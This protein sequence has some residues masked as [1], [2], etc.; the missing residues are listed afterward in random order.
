[1]LLTGTPS[2]TQSAGPLDTHYLDLLGHLRAHSAIVAPLRARRQVIGALTVAGGDGRQPFTEEDLSLVDELCRGLA[3]GVDNARLYQETRNIA[4]RLQRSLLPVLPN[5]EHLQLA[6]RYAASSTTAQVGGDWYDCFVV[7]N[8]E[9]AVVIGDVTGHDLEAAVV[10]SQLRSTV[11][12]YRGRPPG[13]PGN[14]PAPSG[15]G[16]PHARP[17][18]HRHVHLRSRPRR[19]GRPWELVHSS[20]GHLPPLLTA[21]DG[22][23]RYLDAGSGLLLGMD[24]DAQRPTATDSDPASLDAAAVHRRTHRTAWRVPGRRDGAPSPARIRPGR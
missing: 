3:L 20:A 22:R 9:T 15:H 10:M 17:G 16:Q 2:P 11:A 21:P 5:V 24:P 13:A 7:P 14:S 12:R 8:G 23:T 1:M 4:E 19:S 18:G 6:A